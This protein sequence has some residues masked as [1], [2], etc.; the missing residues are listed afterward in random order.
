MGYIYKITNKLNNKIYIGKTERDVQTRWKEHVRHSTIYPN[1]PLYRAILKYGE[2]NFII[3]IIEEC[4]SQ[5]ID[6]REIHWINYYNTYHGQGYNCTGGGEGGIKPAPQAEINEIA[7]RYL[8]GERLDLLCKE[9][10][11]DYEK[12][13]KQLV[14]EKNITINTQ[15]GP[16]K[17]AKAIVAINP[18]NGEI[19]KEYVSISEASRDLCKE[20]KN[21][22]V[23]YNHI[24]A[25]LGKKNIRYGYKW[26]YKKNKIGDE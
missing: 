8:N 1:I 13:R 17:N 19:V 25:V 16:M 3:E 2:E 23:V 12:I 14:E 6:N 4:S 20:G 24:Q 15:A 7:K 21:P 26:D 10:H 9:F 18:K 11:H 5:N 22:R